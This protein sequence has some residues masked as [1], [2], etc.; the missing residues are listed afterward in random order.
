MRNL[1]ISMSFF[2]LACGGAPVSPAADEGATWGVEHTVASGALLSVWGSGPDDVWAAGGQANRGLILHFDGTEWREM[3]SGATSLLWWVYG[4]GR[5]DVYAVGE[6]GYVAHYDGRAWSQV[7]TGTDKTLYG[8]WGAEGGDVWIVGGVP[9]G[10]PG[11]AV[12]LRGN[13]DGFHEVTDLPA[14]LLPETLFKI[15][16]TPRDGIVAVGDGGVVLRYDGAWKRH[17]VPMDGPLI[18]LWG[19]GDGDLYAVGGNAF[20]VMFHYDGQQWSEVLGMESGPGLFGVYTSPGES[21]FAVGAGARVVEMKPGSAPVEHVA[22]DMDST[23]V[24][25]SVWGDGQGAVYA[26]GGSLFAYP[27]P[28]DG[29]VLVRR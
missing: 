15:Y 28:M 27:A 7:P 4:F 18:S 1:L 17:D 12:I 13:A 6:R 11:D 5:D 10:Q 19:R 29:V 14:A 24:L 8:L 25:H 16:G 26:V 23:S 3:A 21:V 2:S 22:P 20:G 9:N